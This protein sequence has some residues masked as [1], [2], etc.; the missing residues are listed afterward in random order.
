MS[1][2]QSSQAFAA[3]PEKY[4]PVYNDFQKKVANAG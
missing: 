2:I 1:R 3:N 4:T